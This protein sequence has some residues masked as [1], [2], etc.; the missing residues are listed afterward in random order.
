MQAECGAEGMEAQRK[1]G[2]DSREAWMLGTEIIAQPLVSCAAAY[3][4]RGKRLLKEVWPCVVACACTPRTW[5][6][7][8]GGSL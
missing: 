2:E 5:E 1:M 8:T 3:K 6:A 4:R 7:K